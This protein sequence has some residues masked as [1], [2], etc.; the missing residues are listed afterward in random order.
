MVKKKYANSTNTIPDDLMPL[1]RIVVL[2]GNPDLDRSGILYTG[3]LQLYQRPPKFD[4]SNN[5]IPYV[6]YS[7]ESDGDY[8]IPNITYFAKKQDLLTRYKFLG[9]FLNELY[10]ILNGTTDT[11]A[12]G[13][14]ITEDYNNIPPQFQK[15]DFRNPKPRPRSTT[16]LTSGISTR[17]PLPPGISPRDLPSQSISTIGRVSSSM[18]SGQLATPSINQ[19]WSPSV[20]SSVKLSI[21]P[22]MLKSQTQLLS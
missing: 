9:E 16:T 8:T 4:Q 20:S 14:K 3:D 21:P 5:L 10:K 19:Y 7:N 22:S 13:L 1:A 11:S 2:S 6:K 15:Y 18:L 12:R 17:R